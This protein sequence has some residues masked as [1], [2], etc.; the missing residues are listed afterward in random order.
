MAS[1]SH[2]FGLCSSAWSLSTNAAKCAMKEKE[3][4]LKY[5]LKNRCQRHMRSGTLCN[6]QV[7]LVSLEA[8][9]K[10]LKEVSTGASDALNQ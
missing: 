2:G 7:F 10:M 9:V 4:A 6:V 8:R 1:S 5:G 3:L